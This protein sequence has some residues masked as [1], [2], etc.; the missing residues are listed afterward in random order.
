MTRSRDAQGA[1]V[2]RRRW[3]PAA[4]TLDALI[5]EAIVD[6]YG[7]D[8]QRV[9]FLTMLEQRLDMPFEVQILGAPAKVER[10]DEV[11]HQIVAI[12][13]SGRFRQAIPILELPLPDPRPGGAEWIEAYRRF[14]RRG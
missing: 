1:R 13:R 10:I 5:E 3:P 6:A 7:D 14:V 9:G 8:E 2:A 12:C 4:T 11:D